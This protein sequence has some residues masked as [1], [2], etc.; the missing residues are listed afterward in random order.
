MAQSCR[1]AMTAGT[2]PALSARLITIG[3]TTETPA[4]LTAAI[5]QAKRRGISIADLRSETAIPDDLFDQICELVS[6]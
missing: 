4:L 2:P 1:D 5:K 3:E 6:A